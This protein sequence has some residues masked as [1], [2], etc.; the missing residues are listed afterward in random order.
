[1]ITIGDSITLQQDFTVTFD[2][3]SSDL[4]VPSDQCVSCVCLSSPDCVR[5]KYDASQSPNYQPVLDP[6]TQK[7]ATFS[8]MYGSGN[9]TCVVGMDTL[10][11]GAKNNNENQRLQTSKILFGA[12]VSEK[13]IFNSFYADGIFGLAFPGAAS[14]KDPTTNRQYWP[15]GELFARNPT[16]PSFFS[17]FLDKVPDDDGGGGGGG[18]GGASEI[19]FGGYDKTLVNNMTSIP[20]I[21]FVF[22]DVHALDRGPNGKAEAARSSIKNN[23][24]VWWLINIRPTITKTRT[25]ALVADLCG[26]DGEND[27][28]S[29]SS[30][31]GCFALVDTGTSLIAVPSTK[32]KLL[33]AALTKG[34][35]LSIH[36][37]FLLLSLSLLLLLLLLFCSYSHYTSTHFIVHSLSSSFIIISADEHGLRCLETSGSG[38]VICDPCTLLHH[39]PVSCYPTLSIDIPLSLG[40]EKIND[41]TGRIMSTYRLEL[42][43]V[44]Y[45]VQVPDGRGSK[46]FSLG[47]WFFF[48]L[49]CSFVFIVILPTS[50]PRCL[51]S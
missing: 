27:G 24:Y 13:S 14:L 51:L 33:L 29:S 43:P 31:T 8:V 18:G 20:S 23:F 39:D 6:H 50:S 5:H 46:Y 45:M 7:Q 34:G 11:I 48:V 17:V 3:G 9:V 26:D 25:G 12:A 16:L 1:M 19:I 41:K 32:W 35:T 40:T 47:S 36:V 2:T 4:W 28:G 37:D 15:I 42:H 22:T 10:E 30:S 38:R 49:L 21:P 44:D